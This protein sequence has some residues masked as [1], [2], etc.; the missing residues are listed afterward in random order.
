MPGDIFETSGRKLIINIFNI[1]LY[2]FGK[3]GA[4]KGIK[5]EHS[6][7]KINMLFKQILK[8]I[9]AE[10]YYSE[11]GIR[12]AS[13]GKSVV[14]ED[15]IM[16]AIYKIETEEKAAEEGIIEGDGEEGGPQGLWH[17]MK[18]KQIVTMFERKPL[19]SKVSNSNRLGSN[20]YMIPYKCPDCG[21]NI[22]MSV[23]PNRRELLIDTEEGRV[24][25]A[26]IY[27]CPNAV[28]FILQ[29]LVSCCLKV[30]NTFLILMMILK[31]RKIIKSLLEEKVERTATII[32]ICMKRNILIKYITEIKALPRYA[33]I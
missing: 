1:L 27:M 20:F 19:D 24:Y 26:R 23:Y 25:A 13:N 30:M 8:D 10:T 31:H 4:I 6:Y 12:F 17:D 22:H 5:V 15:I 16:S 2:V 28:S 21:R 29:D 18:W 32:L 3:W 11:N 7:E 9:G 14:F 33:V